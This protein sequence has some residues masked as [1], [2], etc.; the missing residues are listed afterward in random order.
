MNL[1][2]M[3]GGLVHSATGHQ[4]AVEKDEAQAESANTSGGLLGSVLGTAFTS[5]GGSQLAEQFNSVTGFL[6]PELKA[7]LVGSALNKIG[8]S[9]A[10]VQALLR[11]LGINPAIADN[12]EEATPDE[13][14]RLSEHLQQSDDDATE[15]ASDEQEF[16]DETTVT[17]AQAQ[18]QGDDA[19]PADNSDDGDAGREA[20]NDDES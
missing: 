7:N 1:Q 17:Q 14:A 11:Q 6:S 5:V 3:I 18:E 13:L 20:E 4:E 19:E 10:D 2:D 8:A 9:G 16:S 15:E 12:P